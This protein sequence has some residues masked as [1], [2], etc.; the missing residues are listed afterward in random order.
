VDEIYHQALKLLRRRDY[1]VAQLREKLESRFGEVPREI[2]DT[3]QKKRFLDDAR[4]AG[5]FVVK[6]RDFH[7][8]LVREELLN[9]GVSPEIV[10]H[11][12]SVMD[13]P[14]L[15]H[16]VRAKMIDWKL[17]APIHRREASRLYRT[18]TRLGYPEDEIREEL[19]QLHEQ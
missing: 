7:P 6:R 18:L 11:A 15:Q 5:N 4:Y 2:I 19:E 9:S 17:Q 14:S 16:V 10:D 12:L 8:S 13:W 3:L 1:T